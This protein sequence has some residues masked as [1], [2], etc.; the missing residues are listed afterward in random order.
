MKDRIPVFTLVID[1]DETVCRRLRGWLESQAHEVVTLTDP[2][3]G[4]EHAAQSPPDLALVDL[5]LPDVDGVEIVSRLRE[6]S[7]LTRV[8]AMCAFPK[9]EDVEA[10]I[11]AGAQALLEK[12]VS[13]PAL[14]EVATRQLA[15]IGIPARTEAEFNSRLG[16]RLRRLRSDAG[17]TQQDVAELVG[18]TPAQL[19][20]IE[21]GKTATSTWTLARICATLRVPLASVFE[22]M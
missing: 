5:R 17:R 8:V 14:I 9:P 18:I 1:D 21:S 2:R 4:V 3:A 11:G 10:A 22:D 12:P 6:A 7:P 20:Q 15:A 13:R 16:S 19:S